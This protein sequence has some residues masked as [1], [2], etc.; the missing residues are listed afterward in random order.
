MTLETKDPKKVSMAK[1]LHA[2][3]DGV[4]PSSTQKDHLL[5]DNGGP[6]ASEKE[7][8]IDGPQTAEEEETVASGKR[9]YA[10]GTKVLK[11]MKCRLL[12]VYCHSR[13]HCSLS[14]FVYPNS[15]LLDTGVLKGVSSNLVG[16]PIALFTVM[17][18][19]KTSMNQ[20]WMPF[21]Y[22]Q[23]RN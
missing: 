15:T 16:R 10:I 5:R 6:K 19:L 23:T 18:T 3:K 13:A 11:V 7:G 9:K 4:E 21:V 22:H 8:P 1:T 12:F 14:Y 20:K 17:P 2:E